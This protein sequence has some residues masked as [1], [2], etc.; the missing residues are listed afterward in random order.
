[1][2]T[3]AFLLCAGGGAAQTVDI[4]QLKGLDVPEG[5]K[6][7]LGAMVIEMRGMEVELRNKTL[8]EEELRG[9][10]SWLKKDR[11]AFQN[12]TRV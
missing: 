10:I 6:Q 7:F 8:V 4:N 1:M 3:A 5:L 9:E 11:E 12:K 2:V